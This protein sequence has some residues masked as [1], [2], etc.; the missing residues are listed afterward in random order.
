M[1]R[2]VAIDRQG[3]VVVV[4]HRLL[5]P[6][7]PDERPHAVGLL[8]AYEVDGELSWEYRLDGT[9]VEGTAVAIVPGDAVVA[10]FRDRESEDI[11]HSVLVQRGPKGEMGWEQRVDLASQEHPLD[12][13]AGPDGTIAWV[14]MLGTGGTFSDTTGRLTVLDASGSERWRAELEND[15][16]AAGPR[17][18]TSVAI[19]DS[20]HV[21]TAGYRWEE[22]DYY[23]SWISRYT[24][25]GELH[26]DTTVDTLDVIHDLAL[27]E[28]HDV[29]VVGYDEDEVTVPTVRLSPQLEPRWDDAEPVDAP[30]TG[31]ATDDTGQIVVLGDY[32]V[33]TLTPDGASSHRDPRLDALGDQAQPIGIA[34]GPDGALAIIGH[35]DVEPW[36]RYD[37]WIVRLH[38]A[39]EAW[40]AHARPGA[41]AIGDP[42]GVWSGEPSIDHAVADVLVR[43][44]MSTGP[45]HDLELTPGVEDR[46]V[47]VGLLQGGSL[48]CAPVGVEIGPDETEMVPSKPGPYSTYDDPCV[49][50]GMAADSVEALAGG[51]FDLVLD[52]LAVLVVDDLGEDS[53]Y[54]GDRTLTERIFAQGIATGHGVAAARLMLDNASDEARKDALEY[55]AGLGTAAS[56]DV[57][58]EVVDHD[59]C[60]L[61]MYA[62]LALQAQGEPLDV[63]SRPRGADAQTLMRRY[64][65]LE[66]HPDGRVTAEFWASLLGPNERY[67]VETRCMGDW[68]DESGLFEPCEEQDRSTDEPPSV[69][70]QGLRCSESECQINAYSSQENISHG[71]FEQLHFR[72]GRDGELYVDR[73][74]EVHWMGELP[75]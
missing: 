1:L 24:P 66:H 43:W 47:A 67:R 7:T 34:T 63:V 42:R 25:D 55:I 12:I 46:A 10:A 61:A 64:C 74:L 59:T 5:A 36:A 60:D 6:T 22:Y 48:D 3:R 14:A 23:G 30:G 20:G 9:W 16:F 65:M 53:R 44:Q 68:E 54:V 71:G 26:G 56:R 17:V 51:E 28:D 49:R 8:A 45:Q 41:P 72:R 50:A 37:S 18:A 13:A 2:D 11:D 4:G 75:R 57:L 52:A 27:M 21:F 29:V 40:P 39:Q 31:V 15:A 38:G 62:A 33:L 19:D 58:R 69:D 35:Q 73:L 32:A 70:A